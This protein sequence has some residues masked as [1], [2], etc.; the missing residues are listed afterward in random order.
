MPGVACALVVLVSRWNGRQVALGVARVRLPEHRAAAR[1]PDR[2]RVGEA[3]DPGHRAEVMVEAAIFLHRD[4]DVLDV[5]ER[6][7]GRIG[8]RGGERPAQAGGQH[9]RPG[10]HPGQRG[11]AGEQA[12]PGE[13]GPGR[14][15]RMRGVRGAIRGG[16]PAPP[17]SAAPDQVPAEAGDGQGEQAPAGD[18][19]GRRP[20][21]R[22]RRAGDGRAG[23]L[24]ELDDPVVPGVG[25][26]DRPGRGD[27]QALRELQVLGG[28]ARVRL[29]AELGVEAPGRAEH[30]HQ[31]VVRLRDVD[32][33][34][35][36]D[37]DAAR[38]A[39][40]TVSRLGGAERAELVPGRGELAHRVTPGQGVGGAGHP[41]VAAG[42][43]PDAGRRRHGERDAVAAVG[44]ELHHPAVALVGDPDVAGGR[45]R[46]RHR[47]VQPLPAAPGRAESGQHP[48]GG[49]ELHH[50]AM[51]GV[52]HPD[53]P[54]RV[55]GHAGRS[56]FWPKR[57]ASGRRRRTPPPGHARCRPP[58]RARPR[59]RPRRRAAPAPAVRAPGR[60]AARAP[61][62]PALASRR[63]PGRRRAW[64][65]A[66]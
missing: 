51:P 3:P 15:R 38:V 41:D 40:V 48:A 43:Q 39:E 29:Q 16:G 57:P 60:T 18:Q 30:G 22:S 10:G 61:A 53:V 37:R 49:G 47:L 45:D 20:A 4:D 13:L 46:E 1:Q 8:E 32:P 42:V 24:G 59:R 23:H 26:P 44:G 35:R 52:R 2:G 33:A 28:P 64:P 9:R 50:P 56:R 63:Q 25:H 54:G 5:A 19:K 62:G 17:R 34:V 14:G 58:R 12:A 6:A 7:A 55:D 36:P 31:P 11:G 66:R 65:R 21:R 27:R